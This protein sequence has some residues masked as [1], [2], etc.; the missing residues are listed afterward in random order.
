M[1]ELMDLLLLHK[2]LTG[3][4]VQSF[5]WSFLEGTFSFTFLHLNFSLSFVSLASA[6]KK[7]L[8]FFFQLN[9][10]VCKTWVTDYFLQLPSQ[11]KFRA[12]KSPA[13]QRSKEQGVLGLLVLTLLSWRLPLL[14]FWIY[15]L[16]SNC[17]HL[18]SIMSGFCAECFTYIIL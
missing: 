8:P 11:Q 15:F 1:A 18:L 9:W 5:G 13:V 4:T 6:S 7:N 3:H 16:I 14:P 17:Y 10:F 2:T 12:L